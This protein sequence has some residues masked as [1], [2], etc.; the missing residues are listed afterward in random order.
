MAKIILVTGGA[1]SGKSR[2]AEEIAESH[3]DPLGYVAT[4]QAGDDEMTERIARHQLRRGCQ[5]QAMEEPLRLTEV[6][7]GHDGYFKAM[8]VDCITLWL[9]NLL[10][11]YNDAGRVLADVRELA[12]AM[13]GLKRPLILVTNEVGSGIVPDNPLA[14]TFR[15]LAGEANQI[16]AASADEVHVAISGLS[17]KLKG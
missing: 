17:L 4:C 14:R 7:I 12:A 9:S 1:R 13:P 3:G 2:L 15:D 5:W 6:V 10:F 11:A 8:L 16:L